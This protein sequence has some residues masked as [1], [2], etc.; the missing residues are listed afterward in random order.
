MSLQTRLTDL[1]GAIGADIRNVA[2]R[3]TT[4]EGK[5]SAPVINAIEG[6][7]NINGVGEPQFQSGYGNLDA[8]S[9]DPAGFYKDT[10]GRVFIRGTVK[11]NDAI[12]QTPM[13]T[14]PVGY[15]PSKM[16][17]FAAD[18]STGHAR[19]NIGT[20][21]NVVLWSGSAA[22]YLSIDN[23][24]FDTG[25][26]GFPAFNTV[27]PQEGWHAVGNV[28]AG[29]PPFQNGWAPYVLSAQPTPS[30]KKYLDGRV[31]LQGIAA[32]TAT[33]VIFTLPV[34]YRPIA[35]TGGSVRFRVPAGNT[36]NS[37]NDTQI[38]VGADGTVSYAVG[39]PGAGGWVDLSSVEFDTGLLT[40]P[41]SIA[42]ASV[43]QEAW[44]YIDAPAGNTGEPKFLNG[45]SNTDASTTKTRFRKDPAG[46]VWVEGRVANGPN[47]SDAFILP[48]GYRPSQT[49][50]DYA[51][52][53]GFAGAY[54]QISP[55]GA[56]HLYMSA[57]MADVP[58]NLRFSTDQTTFPAAK[59]I[60]PVVTTLPVGPTDGDEV[61]FLADAANGV[62]WH[63]RYRGKN[64]DGSN[65]TATYK[66]EYVGGAHLNSQSDVALNVTSTTYV[67]GDGVV[68]LTLPLAGD[69]DIGLSCGISPNAGVIA[70]M[71]FQVGA[72]A[73]SDDAGV[74]VFNGAS[75]GIGNRASQETRWN[76]AAAGTVVN[77]VYNSSSGTT[78]FYGR[79]LRARPIRVG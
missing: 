52:G 55:S 1:V 6:W 3:V 10:A 58:F 56:V 42:L 71:S 57:G 61:Y 35:P 72:N 62:M 23:I 15:R 76:F 36:A 73:V 37:I 47:N 38:D 75:S 70:R 12:T 31:R 13:F 30:F 22:A 50:Y 79:R 78:T 32:G 67:T 63:L 39:A 17:I 25:Q 5:S 9:Y 60:I 27:A 53:Q 21:G 46:V 24:S 2:G 66:W 45:W 14:L 20:D 44:H 8:T 28:A 18:C 26:T 65:S 74:Y 59:S 41:T 29:E 11:K 48:P 33:G 16:M 43:S 7:H 4:L 68:K 77:S 69:Y 40:F 51:L 54:V 34:G 19:I 49:V 64:A